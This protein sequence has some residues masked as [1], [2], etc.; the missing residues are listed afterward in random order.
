MLE[1]ERIPIVGRDLTKRY[2]GAA[3]AKGAGN[4]FLFLRDLYRYGKVREFAS[5]AVWESLHGLRLFPKDK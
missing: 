5:F 1:A 3:K 2:F 4:P